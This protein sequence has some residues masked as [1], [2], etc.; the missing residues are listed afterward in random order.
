MLG[1]AGSGKTLLTSTL[2]EWFVARNLDVL[3]LNLDP[4]VKRLPYNPDIDARDYID[5]NKVIEKHS[6]GPNGAMIASMDLLAGKI[7]DIKDEIDYLSP[8]YL[9]VDTPGQME[10]FAYRTSG[11]FISSK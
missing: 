1:T 7:K 2:K 4:G 8:E 3:T 6:L 10:L 9:L 5:I 11:R